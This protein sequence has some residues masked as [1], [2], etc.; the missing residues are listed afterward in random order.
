[1]GGP[2]EKNS[3]C[4]PACLQTLTPE[5]EGCNP[6]EGLCKVRS[7]SLLSPPA[8]PLLAEQEQLHLLPDNVSRVLHC[9]CC[10]LQTKMHVWEVKCSACWGTGTII[11]NGRHGHRSMTTCL[12][13]TGLG[14]SFSTVC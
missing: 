8:P 14:E 4:L 10:V 7:S 9:C 2:Q 1:M 5:E 11:S 12:I 6:E 3:A 13:C